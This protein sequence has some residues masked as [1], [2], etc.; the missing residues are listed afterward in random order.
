LVLNVQDSDVV[1]FQLQSLNWMTVAAP[2]AA[3][4]QVKVKAPADD[5][6]VWV[7]NCPAVQAVGVEAASCNTAVQVRANAPAD[8]SVTF[9]TQFEPAQV[10]GLDDGSAVAHDRFRTPADDSVTLVT[11]WLAEHEE[12]EDA[13]S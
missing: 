8:D 13:A 3:V 9:L 6:V 2:P 5:S 7:T 12:G 11:N 10:G 4:A 1:A